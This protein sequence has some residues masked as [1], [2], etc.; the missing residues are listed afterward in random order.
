MNWLRVTDWGSS[1][2]LYAGFL[3]SLVCAVPLSRAQHFQA[4]NEVD[5][6]EPGWAMDEIVGEGFVGV[7]SKLVPFASHLTVTAPLFG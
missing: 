2:C 7:P 6:T 1:L 3:V 5:F 4:W